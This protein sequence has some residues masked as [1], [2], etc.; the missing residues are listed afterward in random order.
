ML[1]RLDA[2]GPKR[3]LA[4]DGGGIRGALSIGYLQ[5]IEDILRRRHASPHLRLRDY[6]DLIGGTSTGAIIAAGLAVGMSAAEVADHYRLLGPRVFGV[7]RRITGRLRA[8]FDPEALVAVLTEHLGARTLG[9]ESIT[10]GLCIVTKRADTRS[11]WPLHNHPA[12]RFYAANKDIGLVAALRASTAAPFLFTPHGI[13]VGAGGG[14][15]AFIDGAVSTANNPSLLLLLVATLEGFPFH[16]NTGRDDLLITSIGTGTWAK[17]VP[18]QEVLDHRLWD[19]AVEV[20]TMLMEDAATQADLMLRWFGWTP[21]PAVVDLEIG[22]LS[23]D[24]LCEGPLLTY[25]RFDPPLDEAGLRAVGR[26]DLIPQL[27]SLRQVAVGAN[28]G[29]LLDLGRA[30][31]RRDLHES[32]FPAAFDLPAPAGGTNPAPRPPPPLP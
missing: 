12:G 17:T 29:P 14:L 2:D 15:G 18:P 13:D 1:E 5:Q 19:W 9:D 27:G 10:T 30:L 21:T 3:I 8:L 28:V 7:K 16:W 24:R 22:D 11:I 20:P 23:G 25:Q 32:L 26:A 4:L 31:A 6:Y